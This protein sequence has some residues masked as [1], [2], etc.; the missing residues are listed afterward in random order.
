MAAAAT[1]SA[2]L[3]AKANTTSTT[4]SVEITE[5][6]EANE[7]ASTSRRLESPDIFC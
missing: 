2:L 1:V 7:E 5:E 6:F 4:S 3:E